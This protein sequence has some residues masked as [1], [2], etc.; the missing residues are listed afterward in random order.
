[1]I[2]NVKIVSCGMRSF[3]RSFVVKMQYSF[4]LCLN[5]NILVHGV[6]N[7]KP[8]NFCDKCLNIRVLDE[9]HTLQTRQHNIEPTVDFHI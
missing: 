7:P 6:L 3:T 8:C 4:K 5:N 1:M 2:K 9:L